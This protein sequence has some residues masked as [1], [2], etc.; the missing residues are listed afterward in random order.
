MKY[1]S[2]ILIALFSLNLFIS[3]SFA[4][5]ITLFNVQKDAIAYI[6]T[7]DELT[8]YSWDGKPLAYLTGNNIYGFNGKHLG[9]FLNDGTV[10]D[11]QGYIV[12]G[13]QSVFGNTNFEPFKSFKE[14]KPFKSFQEFEPMM[15]MMQN[16]LSPMPLSLFL[17]QGKD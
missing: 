14:F 4:E 12:G 15:P 10:R 6:D 17:Y 2:V 1:F 5:E 16:S 7:N 8:I 11:H 13:V 9:W 3:I